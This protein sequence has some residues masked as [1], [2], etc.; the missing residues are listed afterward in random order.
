ARSAAANRDRPMTAIRTS[1]RDDGIIR[2]A[3]LKGV[4]QLPSEGQRHPGWGARAKPS[5]S[6]SMPHGPYAV[7]EK[8]DAAETAP[9]QRVGLP[10]ERRL[11]QSIP[12]ATTANSSPPP[13][14]TIGANQSS[15]KESIF[16]SDGRSGG[17][18][19]TTVSPTA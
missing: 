7:N 3:W 10:P 12:R 11:A 14:K 5:T 13:P 15:A 9:A 6:A 4:R 17:Y 8:P 16:P 19:T 2:S 18:R 1:A